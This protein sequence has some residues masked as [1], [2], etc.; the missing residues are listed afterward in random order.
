MKVYT[1]GGD[2]GETSLFGGTRVWKDDPRVMAY[3]SV[4]TLNAQVGF[5]KALILDEK[6][7]GL[8]DGVQQDLF[9]LSAELASDSVG[10]SKLSKH[11]GIDAITTLENQIDEWSEALPPVTGWIIPGEDVV[12]AL[13]HV[14]RTAARAAERQTI[15]ALGNDPKY[16][17]ILKYLNR[18]SDYIFTLS[19]W[20]E[21]RKQ[22]EMI[23]Q[24]VLK[25]LAHQ[26]SNV[27]DLADAII[28]GC[29][30]KALEMNVK[31]N[32]AIVDGG[33][34]LIGFKRMEDAFLGS[35]D[36]AINKAKT[37]MRFKMTTATLGALAK[38][39]QPLYGIELSN[40]GETVIFGG[41]YPIIVNDEVIGAVGI[42]GGSVEEDEAIAEAGL[43]NI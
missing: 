18:L 1:K 36:I 39:D 8:L 42:S 9:T 27:Y 32:I 5:L 26:S 35:I 11:I 24:G 21:Y 40:K 14:V 15:T 3:G 10:R 25:H 20:L 43:S 22:F 7:K 6:I 12:S 17:Y 37:S 19:R 2:L 4:D 38:P 34:H 41:G 13:A 16:Q 23:K 30:K 29:L 28:S 33:C 31:V